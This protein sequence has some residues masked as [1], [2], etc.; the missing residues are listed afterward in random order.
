MTQKLEILVIED[1]PSYLA[2][3]KNVFQKL[4]DL[5]SPIAITFVTTGKEAAQILVEKTFDGIIS[6]IFFPWEENNISN[7]GKASGKCFELLNSVGALNDLKLEA[8]NALDQWLI[9]HTIPPLGI[10]FADIAVTNKIP[11]VLCT[12]A[13]SHQID[14][15]PIV[16]YLQLTKKNIGYVNEKKDWLKALKILINLTFTFEK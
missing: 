9:A 14:T 3:A 11:V 15:D 8:H 6:D 1:N 4:I 7:W 10:M 12:D 13:K 16:Y 5:G 2:D